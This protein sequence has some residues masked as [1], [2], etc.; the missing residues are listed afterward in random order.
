[1]ESVFVSENPININ[2]FVNECNEVQKLK[3]GDIYQLKDSSLLMSC[4]HCLQEFQYFTEFSLHIQ[5]HYLRNEVAQ[6]QEIKDGTKSYEGIT[7]STANNNQYRFDAKEDSIQNAENAFFDENLKLANVWTDVQLMDNDQSIFEPE[8]NVESGENRCQP[9]LFNEG[10]DYEKINGIYKCYNCDHETTR[11]EHFRDH[12]QT[13]HSNEKSIFCPLCS[14]A[15]SAISYVRKHVNRTHKMKITA[16]KIREAQ[17]TFSGLA[18]N[19]SLK[20]F[21]AK[22]F[23]E[24]E[25][26]EKINGRFKCL[27]CGREMLDHIKEHLLTHTNAKNIFCPICDKP[28]IAVS[29]VRKHV[30]RAHKMKITAEEIKTAQMSIFIP[31]ERKDFAKKRIESSFASVVLCQ[32]KMEN[33]NKYFECFDC[34]RQFMSLSSLRIHL[35]L[36]SGIKYSCPHCDKHFAM[37]SYVRDHIVAMHGIKRDE[38]PRDSIQPAKS[39]L[40]FEPPPNPDQFECNLCKNQYDRRQKLRQHMKT[41]TAG[42]FLCVTC[43]AVY[44]T[45]ANLRYHMER[46]QADPDKRHKCNECA[47]TYP[48]RRYMLSHYRTVHLNKRRNKPNIDQKSTINN[49]QTPII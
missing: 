13:T 30:N 4:T 10:T 1:M 28:F 26:Y 35:K 46:H 23:A 42:P 2:F 49:A 32:N 34:H 20:S 47:K 25:D 31:D 33:P 43:G 37:R 24:G 27:T 17:P 22:S 38:I 9:E 39:P 40:S 21:E 45:I 7:S 3:I 48:T 15:F 8:I 6:L 18:D 19:S 36:H 12:L 29:Y 41:H 44:K 14:K 5:E 16:D 11:W